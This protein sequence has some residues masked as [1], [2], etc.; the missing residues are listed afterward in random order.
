MDYILPLIFAI[1][2]LPESA[3]ILTHPININAMFLLLLQ[4]IYPFQ[5]L[6]LI[7]N[8]N[9]TEVRN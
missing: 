3:I 1:T 2:Q 9:T 8:Q 7:A 4:L 6:L 5:T